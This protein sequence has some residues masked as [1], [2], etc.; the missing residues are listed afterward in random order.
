MPGSMPEP[1][2]PA[3]DFELAN[4]F[5]EPVGPSRSP[6]RIAV[7]VFYPFAFSGICTSELDELRD[8]LDIF[9]AR[10][11]QLLAVSIDSKYT[12]RAFAGAKGYPFDL[13]SDFWPHGAVAEAYGVFN[14][15]RGMAERGSFVL[16][17]NGVLRAATVSPVGQPRKLDWYRQALDDLG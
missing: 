15:T 10:G 4:Q 6:G 17:A 7:V 1:G 13:L 11:A 5:G 12:L 2:Q 8:N 16:D 14:T 3:P 9:T